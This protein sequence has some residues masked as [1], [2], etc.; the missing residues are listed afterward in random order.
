M[1]KVMLL[2]TIRN[3]LELKTGNDQS[4][5][6]FSLAVPHR[7]KDRGVDFISCVAWNKNAEFMQKY[8]HKGNR[9]CISGRI[10]TG[11]YDDKD[12]KRIYTTDVVVEEVDFADSKAETKKEE[13]TTTQPITDDELP[14]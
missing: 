2:G 11:Q 8:F 12:G 4:Y 13:T 6:K 3:E 9:I 10:L 1:N 7:T 14:F 5:V